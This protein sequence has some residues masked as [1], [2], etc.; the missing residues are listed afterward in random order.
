MESR[1]DMPSKDELCYAWPTLTQRCDYLMKFLVQAS[2]KRKISLMRKGRA[3]NAPNDLLLSDEDLPVMR[4][5]TLEDE[6]YI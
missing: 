2:L 5:Q 6:A 1:S 3:L 4:Q